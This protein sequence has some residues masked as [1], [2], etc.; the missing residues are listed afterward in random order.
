M[1]NE[2]LI[3]STVNLKK[4]FRVGRGLNPFSHQEQ[5]YVRAVDG[6]SLSIQE[7]KTVGVVGESG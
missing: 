2:N 7:G 6:V 1:T 3:L 4:Y 5:K